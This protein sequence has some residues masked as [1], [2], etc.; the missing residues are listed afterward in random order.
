MIFAVNFSFSQASDK[1]QIEW[2]DFGSKEKI[3]YIDVSKLKSLTEQSTVDKPIF[4]NWDKK[5][6][7]RK[8]FYRNG[9]F[10]N[11]SCFNGGVLRQNVIHYCLPY[12]DI[13]YHLS[14]L[15]ESIT[16]DFASL[17]GFGLDVYYE[18]DK[19]RYYFF[20]C[21]WNYSEAF[22]P[23]SGDPKIELP[24]A[25]KPV[26]TK[27]LRLKI[28]TEVSQQW[29]N[30]KADEETE[31]VAKDF[32][33]TTGYCPPTPRR[34]QYD[35]LLGFVTKFRIKN[36]GKKDLYIY[37]PDEN[38]DNV[39]FKP[40]E[41]IAFNRPKP[42]KR[43]EPNPRKHWE[44]FPRGA[45]REFEIRGFGKEKTDAMCLIYLNDK[46]I[47]WD[48]IEFGITFPVMFREFKVN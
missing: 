42:E 33:C 4:L 1:A 45:T 43:V 16:D 2:N 14:T 8:S 23:F 21:C 10:Y 31:I 12:A 39:L 15:D 40:T 29:L 25:I 41:A 35:R 17:Y 37:I 3:A 27:K 28:K 30:P 5:S 7:E 46:P 9:E 13:G 38:E 44:I 34:L 24:K 48:E 20:G 6:V 19:N 36:E 22:G 47:F 11:N 18:V 32:L 26:R